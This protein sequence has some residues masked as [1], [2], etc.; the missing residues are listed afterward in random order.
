MGLGEV[1]DVLN[2]QETQLDFLEGVVDLH[3]S[4]LTSKY[5]NR[6]F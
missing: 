1:K 2:S 3:L 5:R 6:L 4:K